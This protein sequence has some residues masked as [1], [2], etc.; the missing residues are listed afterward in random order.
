M[1]DE[2]YSWYGSV[3]LLSDLE[4]V[5]QQVQ[6]DRVIWGRFVQIAMMTGG[7][8]NPRYRTR[9]RTAAPN[10]LNGNTNDLPLPFKKLV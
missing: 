9:K 8:A 6:H 7:R 10:E 5:G 4:S 1:I 3:C 2:L